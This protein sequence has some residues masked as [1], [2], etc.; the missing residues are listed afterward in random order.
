MRQTVRL[1]MVLALLLLLPA[2]ALALTV[3]VTDPPEGASVSGVIVPN[4]AATDISGYVFSIDWAT[5]GFANG[6]HTISVT[7]TDASGA[8]TTATRTLYV[9]NPTGHLRLV[10]VRDH[11]EI[12]IL[13]GQNVYA[14]A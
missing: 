8:T 3:T 5:T 6:P 7:A 10:S 12:S 9:N 13:V 1:A 4:A 2:P 11:I 14:D